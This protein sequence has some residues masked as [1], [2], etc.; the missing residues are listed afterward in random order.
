V[1]R[2]ARKCRSRAMGRQDTERP[3]PLRLTPTPTPTP[4]PMPPLALQPEAPQMAHLARPHVRAAHPT[5]PEPGPRGALCRIGRRAPCGSTGGCEH[6]APA[7]LPDLGAR[8]PVRRSPAQ[9]RG[10]SHVLSRE[11]NQRFAAALRLGSW[12]TLR[13]RVTGHTQPPIG[14]NGEHLPHDGPYSGIGE[15]FPCQA[16]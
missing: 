7:T 11:G 8:A 12:A 1:P 3:A 4:T 15:L 16:D 2:R 13:V 10:R 9:S 6:P 5:L 14:A